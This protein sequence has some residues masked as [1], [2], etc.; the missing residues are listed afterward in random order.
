VNR[1]H[2]GVVLRYADPSVL[3]AHHVEQKP[4]PSDRER[5][6]IIK[7]EHG[8]IVLEI[9]LDCL[10]LADIARTRIDDEL[11]AIYRALRLKRRSIG[12][13]LVRAVA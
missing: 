1:N 2:E 4:H 11:R 3:R 12:M 7:A 6:A 9:I 10:D 5:C 8:L 13:S